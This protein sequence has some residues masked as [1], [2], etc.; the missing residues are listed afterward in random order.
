MFRVPVPVF[1]KC[2]HQILLSVWVLKHNFGLV[3]KAS[4]AAEPYGPVIESYL[5]RLSFV[6]HPRHSLLL[7][8]LVI[9][10]PHRTR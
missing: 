5:V 1:M 8:S 2:D 10:V 3:C 9:L 7:I 6:S 4:P